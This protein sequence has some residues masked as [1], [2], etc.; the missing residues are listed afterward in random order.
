MISFVGSYCDFR[1][2]GDFPHDK[3]K[4]S[5]Y[6]PWK[7]AHDYPSLIRKQTPPR[8]IRIFLQDGENDLDNTLGNWFKNNE[9]MADALAFSGYQHKVAWGQGM[10]SKKHGMSLLPEILEWLWKEK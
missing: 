2:I 1:R 7:T 6:G 5:E 8:N 9:R 3:G 4:K 10:H